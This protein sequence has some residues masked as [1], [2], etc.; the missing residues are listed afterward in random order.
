MVA[1]AAH[2]LLIEV[3]P[4]DVGK[5]GELVV[6]IDECDRLA[7]W[8]RSRTRLDVG[9]SDMRWCRYGRRLDNGYPRHYRVG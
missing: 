3:K 5:W 2:W 8:D 4:N 7:T 9:G 6:Q 1:G